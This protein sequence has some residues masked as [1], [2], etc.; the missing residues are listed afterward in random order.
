MIRTVLVL[1]FY[2]NVGC[3]AQS[4]SAGYL[5]NNLLNPGAY[6]DLELALGS[7]HQ[8]SEIGFYIDPNTH[9]ASFVEIGVGL[10]KGKWQASVLPLGVF[11]TILNRTYTVNANGSVKEASVLQGH[12]YYSPG[13]SIGRTWLSAGRLK[14]K[15]QLLVLSP[16]NFGVMPHVNVTIGYKIW[17]R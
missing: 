16:Y 12:W 10:Q 1:L 17:E 15:L 5:G 11:R 6:L 3:Q 9:S 2:A 4:I 14:T 8:V 7:Y 13:L